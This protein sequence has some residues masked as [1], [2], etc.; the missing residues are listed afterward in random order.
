LAGDRNIAIHG[1]S[2]ELPDHDAGHSNDQSF[3]HSFSI[4]LFTRSI[5]FKLQQSELYGSNPLERGWACLLLLHHEVGYDVLTADYQ[6]TATDDA[7][8]RTVDQEWISNDPG[9]RDRR[10]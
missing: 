9:N 3:W 1:M 10:I 4:E 8:I 6:L 2:G 7:V 5:S